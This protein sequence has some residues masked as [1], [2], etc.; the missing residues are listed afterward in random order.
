MIWILAPLA[1][2]AGKAIYDAVTDDGE[3]ERNRQE[4]ESRQ[5]RERERMRKNERDQEQRRA[6]EKQAALLRKAKQDQFVIDAQ[7]HVARFYG[8]QKDL[9]AS[10]VAASGQGKFTF[11]DVKR[12]VQQELTQQPKTSQAM[13]DH[14]SKLV[15]GTTLSPSQRER[16]QHIASLERDIAALQNLAMT[17]TKRASA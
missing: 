11:P 9:L 17:F 8:Q 12:F 14:L 13:L 4:Q 3:T 15:P 7:Q 1:V 5:Q 10:T 2:W 16:D 6:L